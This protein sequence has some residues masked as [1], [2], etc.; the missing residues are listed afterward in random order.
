MKGIVLAGGAGTRMWPA[1]KVVPKSLVP[2]GLQPL[3]YYPICTLIAA[4]IDEILI[5]TTPETEH[6]FRQLLGDG[7]QWR[8]QFEYAVQP[9]PK[10]LAQAFTIAADYGW[11]TGR[12]GACLILGDNIFDAHEFGSSLKNHLNVQGGVIFAY[13]VG[14]KRATQFGVVEFDRKSGRVASVTEKPANPKS[15]H[16]IPGLYFFDYRCVEFARA[17][18]PSARGEIEITSVMDSYI[19]QGELKAIP[20]HR[21]EYWLDTG[22][23]T[24]IEDAWS[25]V[26]RKRRIT[27]LRHG[28]PEEAAWRNH[29]ITDLE[30]LA[31]ADTNDPKGQNPYANYLRELARGEHDYY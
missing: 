16:M 5:I 21:S 26:E 19:E 2:V 23:E 29:W 28:V 20:I 25:H 30:L 8:V 18:R 11:L 7:S 24:A 6:L 22:T 27:G 12:E 9:Q 1:T 17:A 3:I 10:G 31:I 14:L 4:Q 15:P 13:H